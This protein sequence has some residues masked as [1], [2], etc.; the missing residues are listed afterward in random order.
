VKATRA[1]A[2]E[3]ISC[4]PGVFAEPIV[5]VGDKSLCAY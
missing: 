4:S 5:P 3:R 1:E 2:L